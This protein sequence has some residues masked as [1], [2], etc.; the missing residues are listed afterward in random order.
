MRSEYGMHSRRRT[1]ASIICW[2]TGNLRAVQILLCHS[3]IENMVRNLG[4]DVEDALA[5]AE[6]PEI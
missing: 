1:E 3:K 5:L 4:V 6:N 2:A